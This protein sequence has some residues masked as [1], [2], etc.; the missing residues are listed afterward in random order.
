MINDIIQLLGVANPQLSSHWSNGSA[1]NLTS[2]GIFGLSCYAA[3]DNFVAPFSGYLS[4]GPELERIITPAGGALSARSFLI[5]ADPQVYLRLSRLYATIIEGKTVH[6][7]LAERP[8]P[9]YFVYTPLTEKDNGDANGKGPKEGIVL[10]GADLLCNGDL[11]IHDQYGYPIDPLAVAAA[12]DAFM[13]RFATMETKPLKTPSAKAPVTPA[14]QLKAL[15]GNTRSTTIQLVSPNGDALTTG[16]DVF[17]NLTDVA[18]GTGLY[19]LS[20]AGTAIGKKAA[21][22]ALK[23][24][25]ATNGLLADSYVPGTPV[26]ALKLG[27][28][29]LRAYVVR[30]DAYLLGAAPKAEP[31]IAYNVA[32]VVRDGEQITLLADGT[33]C[34]GAVNTINL[35]GGAPLLLV[36]PVIEKDFVL[37]KMISGAFARWPAAPAGVGSTGSI[38]ASLNATIV[39]SASFIQDPATVNSDVAVQLSAPQ[40]VPGDWVRIYNRVFRE[41]GS[42]M[43]GD[44]AGAMIDA[45]HTASFRLTDPFSLVTAANQAQLLNGPTLILDLVVI[46]RG[47][48]KRTFGNIRC[49]VAAKAPLPPQLMP[50]DN[51]M[52]NHAELGTSPAGISGTGYTASPAGT[53]VTAFLNKVWS[54]GPPREA[55]RYPTMARYDSI[56]AAYTSGSKTW[57][58]FCGGT[59]FKKDALSSFQFPG[60]PGNPGG[61]EFSSVGVYTAGGLLA[62][63]LAR[64]AYRRTRNIG[65]RI[66]K[67]AI[68]PDATIWS[69]PAASTSTSATWAAAALQTIASHCETPELGLQFNDMSGV[70]ASFSDFVKLI[71]NKLGGIP[72]WLPATAQAKLQAVIDSQASDT[73]KQQGYMELYREIVTSVNGR[74]DTFWALKQGILAARECIYI[75]GGVL[76]RTAGTAADDLVEVLLSQLKAYPRLKLILCL[77]RQVRYGRG[78]EAFEA[79]DYKR[80]TEMVSLLRG[81][82]A[83]RANQVIAFH[84][85]GFPMRPK[86]LR[87]QLVL[88]DDTWALIGS[89]SF[90]RRGFEF[91]GAQDVVAIDKTIV[92]GKSAGIQAFRLKLLEEHLNLQNGA[93]LT[94]GLRVRLRNARE[95]FYALKELLDT[96]GGG[97]ISPLWEGDRQGLAPAPDALA[98]PG[99]SLEGVDALLTALLNGAGTTP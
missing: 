15:A 76:D 10:A 12:F 20:A 70:P 3:A 99:A 74:R 33:E 52:L 2:D 83:E 92:N 6:T 21:D 49:T 75:Q 48:K 39:L 14:S 67:L 53:G 46:N 45:N 64:A 73:K 94:S 41:D 84:P 89:S 32:P 25:P 65:E 44:G 63:D 29:F 62:Y 59:I 58:A 77:S 22:A 16:L 54:D 23:I 68:D 72:S 78:Y 36:S 1:Q 81:A 43:R 5:K 42:E 19:G 38:P 24:G 34:L 96:G 50:L 69:P 95:S 85:N 13:A 97:L 79:H 90:R 35:S 56:A 66:V 86:E 4:R 55:P 47:G 8:V 11:S 87:H 26:A 98:N 91:D 88:I 60:N 61:R 31:S 27:R 80:R 7:H 18:H 40:L 9:C 30:L 71:E 82:A 37:P 28:D 57:Q 51:L 17:S 93:G